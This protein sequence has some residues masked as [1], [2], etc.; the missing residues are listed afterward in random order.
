M[1]FKTKKFIYSSILGI[2]SL[3]ITPNRVYS[4]PSGYFEERKECL[5]NP[6]FI[7]PSSKE[8]KYCIKE[9]GIIKKYDEF[10]NLV[11][12]DIKLDEL[13]EEKI[14][15]ETKKSNK[16]KVVRSPN[17]ELIEYK[18]DD[19][20]L[21]KYSCE[22]KKERGNL[23]CKN[24][25]KKELIGIRPNGF[26]LKKG[27]RE[28]ENKRWDKSTKFFDKEIEYNN[29]QEAYAYRA[30]SKFKLE[31]YLGSIKDLEDALK[32]DKSDIFSLSLRSRANFKL[33]NYQ[34]VIFD[35]NKLITLIEFKSNKEITELFNREI[36]PV[37]NNYFY[38]RGL[39]KSE[40]GDSNGAIKDFNLEIINNPLNGDAYFQKGLEK[41]WVE[42]DEACEDLIK[43]V[44]LGAIDT[45]SEFLED[46]KESNSFLDELFTGSDNK[47]LI[48]ACKSSSTKKAESIKQNYE[49]EKLNI[50]IK[51]LI[52][53]YYF[54][55]PIPLLILGY[56]I[57]KYRSKD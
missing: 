16:I 30:F 12:I 31:D 8:F 29:N 13:I 57:V 28:I 38:L 17:K 18:I 9:N 1:K 20:E 10:D 43:G 26:Y 21:F 40:L 56:T 15:K 49:S 51:N 35:L 27:L 3:L 45:S 6:D 55:I 25:S 37:A 46:T 32:I 44:S 33:K 42:R 24:K 4:N 23:T 41:Y 5:E 54:L 39:A 14:K 7:T 48:D 53:K 11:D 19:E 22:A 47:S 52:K 34:E 2:S 36:N 50:D